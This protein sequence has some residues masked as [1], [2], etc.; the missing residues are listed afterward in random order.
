MSE[1]TPRQTEVLEFVRS[2][3]GQ[4]GYS[5]SV[6]NVAEQFGMAINSAVGHLDA[7]ERKGAI[8]RTP[9]V[10]RSIRICRPMA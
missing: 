3:V 6:R 9:G 1:I 5:P 8:A 7:L 2:Y 4:N 10:A